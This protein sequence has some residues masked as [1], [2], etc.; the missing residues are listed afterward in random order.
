M[1]TWMRKFYLRM[2]EVFHSGFLV[3]KNDYAS[4]HYRADFDSSTFTYIGLNYLKD[5]MGSVMEKEFF[6][7]STDQV[8]SDYMG[9]TQSSEEEMVYVE[10]ALKLLHATGSLPI[11]FSARAEGVDYKGDTLLFVLESME[12]GFKW[13][14]LTLKDLILDEIKVASEV[15]L[16]MRYCDSSLDM[17]VGDSVVLDGYSDVVRGMLGYYFK[18]IG[19]GLCFSGSPV[20]HVNLRDAREMCLAMLLPDA[21]PVYVCRDNDSSGEVN[22]FAY[23]NLNA[24]DLF[25]TCKARSS[26]KS[27][28]IN[29]LSY[30]LREKEGL[31]GNTYKLVPIISKNLSNLLSDKV[32]GY[33]RI[34]NVSLEAT[35]IAH[36]LIFACKDNDIVIKLQSFQELNH[37][38][39]V[40]LPLIKKEVM[41]FKHT[42]VLDLVNMSIPIDD[43]LSLYFLYDDED[44][45]MKLSDI[46]ASFHIWGKKRLRLRYNEDISCFS[47][48]RRVEGCCTDVIF[49][50]LPL[51]DIRLHMSTMLCFSQTNTEA[52]IG[53]CC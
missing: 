20:V 18:E 13:L 17:F 53:D 25:Y 30:V 29:S 15:L 37:F 45:R 48:T 5:Y 44:K 4:V 49:K 7:K 31:S 38:I 52:V 33:R 26:Y 3:M 9:L 36:L 22:E 2:Y 50:K 16:S 46:L 41:C 47:I 8:L 11:R 21:R 35:Y 27:E 24:G 6:S 39:Q 12:D 43:L 23:A 19:K 34:A 42:I 40:I 1:T 32:R 14:V 51:T 10:T 28:M